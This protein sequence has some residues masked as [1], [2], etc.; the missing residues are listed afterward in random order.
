MPLVPR[1][2]VV[3][4]SLLVLASR[5]GGLISS[6]QADAAG[7][8][9]TRRTRLVR[10]G[11]WGRPTHGVYD[12]TPGVRYGVDERR[13][14]AAWTG[15]LAYGPGAVA[16]GSCALA[17]LGVAG[18]PATLAPEVALPAGRHHR[19]RD[20]VRVRCFGETVPLEAVRH[21]A[22]LVAGLTTAL[23]QAVPELGPR[24]A[25]AVLDD[26]T[27][28]GLLS[29]EGALEVRR[30]VVGRRGAAGVRDVWALVD[31]RA[32]SPLE[33]FAR[34]DCTV[35]GLA[36]DELQVELRSTS[37]RLLGR[38]DL[39]WRIDDGRWLL[40][41][42]DGRDVHES[43]AALLHDRH[44]QNALLG[45][46]RVDVLRFAASDLGPSGVMLRTLR[47]HLGRRRAPTPSW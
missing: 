43:P 33:S 45:T 26:V 37:G 15:L 39:G 8:G 9:S 25:L 1:R 18:L 19:P 46:G 3:P 12:P 24:H 22:A 35:A 16:V 21:G 2:A 5:Q 27:R 4:S 13:R 29:A 31:A 17:L 42:I 7:V 32:E 20:G 6:T 38:A 47:A 41:E 14:R 40:V 23:V 10:D 28:R 30:R 44:R 11:M 34:W 36:P